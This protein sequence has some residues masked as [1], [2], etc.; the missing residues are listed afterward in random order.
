MNSSFPTRTPF[1]ART[2]IVL[3]IALLAGQ[4]FAQDAVGLKSDTEKLSYA[5]GMDLGNQLRRKS[6]A[7]DP[8][9]FGRALA[10]A[11]AGGT[12]LMTPDEARAQIAA[13][14]AEMI[15]RQ[16]ENKTLTRNNRTTGT[17]SPA[18]QPAQR[19]AKPD[20]VKP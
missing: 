16:A 2:L 6:V 17:L 18:T 19:E 11:L 9:V 4:A 8:T 20:P 13:L 10:D 1:T 14:Q 12:T 7:V 5:L 15:R 3:A